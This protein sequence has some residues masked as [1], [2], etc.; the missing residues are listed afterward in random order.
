MAAYPGPL[1]AASITPWSSLSAR[2]DTRR[3]SPTAPG[4]HRDSIAG[5]YFGYWRGRLPWADAGNHSHPSTG[6]D[7][8]GSAGFSRL[9]PAKAIDSNNSPLDDRQKQDYRKAV[10][11]S[12]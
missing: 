8:F 2:A 9:A 3:K 11:Q 7:G 12:R 5:G 1:S 4:W 6:P 10:V